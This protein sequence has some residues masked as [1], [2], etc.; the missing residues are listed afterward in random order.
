M[1]VNHSILCRP[2]RCRTWR[3]YGWTVN[4]TG[5]RTSSTLTT[6]RDPQAI[7]AYLK[8]WVLLPERTARSAYQRDR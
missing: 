8:Q 7:S 4:M 6:M 3:R 2:N 5:S 1:N